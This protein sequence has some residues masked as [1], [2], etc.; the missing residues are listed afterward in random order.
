VTINGVINYY[1]IYQIK[2]KSARNRFKFD[3]ATFS[4]AH[5][6]ELRVAIAKESR[7]SRL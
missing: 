7:R 3:G 4:F 5:F 2:I 6:Q 1:Y